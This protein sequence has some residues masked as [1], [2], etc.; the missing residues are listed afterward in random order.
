MKITLKTLAAFMPVARWQDAAF[1][2]AVALTERWD[3]PEKLFVH[4]EEVPANDSARAAALKK[5]ALKLRSTGRDTVHVV[6]GTPALRAELD[7]AMAAVGRGAERVVETADTEQGAPVLRIERE[8]P[9]DLR[10]EEGRFF[11]TRDRFRLTGRALAEDA[12]TGSASAATPLLFLVGPVLGFAGGLFAQNPW[13]SLL[14]L[15]LWGVYLY[16]AGRMLGAGWALLSALC[17]FGTFS[18][19]YYSLSLSRTDQI[20]RAVEAALAANNQP[21]WL[22][23]HLLLF[24]APAVLPLA[25]SWSQRRRRALL[26]LEQGNTRLLENTGELALGHID[27]RRVQAEMA[28]ADT[29]PL[30]TLG[31]ALGVQSAKSDAMAPDKGKQVV[32]SC[33][34]LGTHLLTIGATGSR[35]TSA[36]L[37]PIVRDWAQSG[38]GGALVCDGKAQL[39]VEMAKA[40]QHL[41]FRLID[42]LLVDVGLIEGLT[43]QEYVAAIMSVNSGGNSKNKIWDES[44][45]QWITAAGHLLDACHLLEQRENEAFRAQAEALGQPYKEEARVWPRTYAALCYLVSRLDDTA[46]MLDWTKNQQGQWVSASNPGLQLNGK[47]PPVGGVIGWL[48]AGKMDDENPL[49][50]DA[51]GYVTS[52]VAPM[53]A[54]NVGNVKFTARSWLAPIMDNVHLRRWASVEKG[55]DT[56]GC[57]RGELTG[58][59]TPATVYGVAGTMALALIKER[60]YS[61]LKR[62]PDNWEQNGQDKNV[63][64]MFD[65]AHVAIGN[66]EAEAKLLGIS[67]SLGGSFVFATQSVEAFID[68]FGAD[69]TKAILENFRSKIIFRSGKGTLEWLAG[70]LGDMWA[71]VWQNPSQGLNFMSTA[72]QRL[73]GP[74]YDP[75]NPDGSLVRSVSVRSGFGLIASW[76]DRA[77]HRRRLQEALS[78]TVSQAE[79]RMGPITSVAEATTHLQ[80]PGNGFAS[81]MRGGVERRDYIDTSRYSLPTGALGGAPL[82]SAPAPGAT[83]QA[84]K[85]EAAAPAPSSSGDLDLDDAARTQPEKEGVA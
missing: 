43:P 48:R 5:F 82:K 31:D 47:A 3:V 29:S 1:D 38:Y 55:L 12:L 67:R 24:L 4:T 33:R 15:I 74:M 16:F 13:V 32:V 71:L 46:Y 57:L 10:D 51:F 19:I 84:P 59:N 77:Q 45:R 17:S 69:R 7:K 79:W 39:A 62:R 9:A 73:A 50:S 11:L 75:A 81:L 64:L 14:A 34:D 28:T 54:K 65:E 60:V 35:K 23:W 25:W 72:R 49:W 40:F 44:A 63:L 30:I 6:G 56:T 22:V 70:A 37:R 20:K 78:A 80:K 36:V 8:V 85:P 66:G 26:L 42:P 58:V 27:A 76:R 83:D 2:E 68:A 52:E 18:S 53:D 41:G 61:A 21:L